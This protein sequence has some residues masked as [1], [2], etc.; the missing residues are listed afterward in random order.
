MLTEDDITQFIKKINDKINDCISTE[1]ITVVQMLNQLASIFHHIGT[2]KEEGKYI[3][4]GN[5]IGM[6][7]SQLRELPADF[8]Y[9]ND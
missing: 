6:L 4:C 8:K 2:I 7:S 9:I 1:N 3:I 5:T